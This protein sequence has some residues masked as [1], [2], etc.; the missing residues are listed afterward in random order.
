MLRIPTSVNPE[1][2][3]LVADY[4]QVEQVLINL[5]KNAV[6][7]VSDKKNGV[8]HLKAFFGEEGTYNSG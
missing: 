8:I 7:A 2:I 4:S 6:D 5:I 1:D 3:A